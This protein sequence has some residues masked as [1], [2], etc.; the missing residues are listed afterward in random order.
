MC[1]HSPVWFSLTG[2]LDTSLLGLYPNLEDL[3]TKLSSNY[4]GKNCGDL[5]DPASKLHCLCCDP[6]TTLGHFHCAF[7]FLDLIIFSNIPDL[8]FLRAVSIRTFCSHCLECLSSWFSCWSHTHISYQDRAGRDFPS[9]P[10][11]C[12]DS[13]SFC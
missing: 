9:M 8:S 1:S 6:I 12:H 4:S 10:S 13:P 5:Q 3:I 11:Q 2:D 7:S